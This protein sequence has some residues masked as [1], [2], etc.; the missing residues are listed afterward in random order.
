MGATP[1]QIPLTDHDCTAAGSI[2]PL[3][4]EDHSS[5]STVCSS[6]LSH[7]CI[8][9]TS[10]HHCGRQQENCLR[11][12]SERNSWKLNAMC[13]HKFLRAF[14]SYCATN[15]RDTNINRSA[16]CKPT[17]KAERRHLSAPLRATHSDTWGHTHTHTRSVTVAALVWIINQPLSLEGEVLIED[18]LD[19]EL[20]R[21][22]CCCNKV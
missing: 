1:C 13:P 21:I 5:P 19:L 18:W 7:L 8:F 15:V 14:S 12:A 16:E 11:G 4:C 9:W 22:S 17:S 6:P 3:V 10:Q 2:L 20:S